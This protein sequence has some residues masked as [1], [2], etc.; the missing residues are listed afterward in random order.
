[1]ITHDNFD[2]FPPAFFELFQGNHFRNQPL[3]TYLQQGRNRSGDEQSIVDTAIVG[4]LLR[5][6]GFA[7]GEQ[8]YN[9]SRA[10]GRPDFAPRDAVYGTCFMVEDKAT[11]LD[12]TLDLSDPQSHLSQLANYLREAA[13]PLGW[14][15]PSVGCATGGISWF[16]VSMIR[17]TQPCSLIS[18][19]KRH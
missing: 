19:S 1:M 18:T 16:I 13:V 7:P 5:L 14:L 10:S 3:L 12:L 11:A 8:V 9:E 4:P 15:C 6:L 2:E 17:R